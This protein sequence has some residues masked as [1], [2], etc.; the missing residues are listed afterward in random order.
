MR[1]TLTKQSR[2]EL[3]INLDKAKRF[4]QTK[5]LIRIQAVMI[6]I[7]EFYHKEK[8]SEMLNSCLK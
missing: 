7:D 5:F 3:L 1:I 2:Q 6:F 8:I 4:N